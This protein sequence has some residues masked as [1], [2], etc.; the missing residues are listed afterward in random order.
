M[1]RPRSRRRLLTGS[2]RWFAVVALA[3][4]LHGAA[5][6]QPPSHSQVV[7]AVAF[8]AN[9]MGVPVPPDLPPVE[10]RSPD[11]LYASTAAVVSSRTRVVGTQ[12]GGAIGLQGG[13]DGRRLADMSWL[14]HETAHDLQPADRWRC[15]D[16]REAEAYRVQDAWLRAHGS[17]LAAIGVVPHELEPG[18]LCGVRVFD[19]RAPV[20]AGLPAGIFA[21]EPERIEIAGRSRP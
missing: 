6:A 7:A 3:G 20:T 12:R 10:L 11:A 21:I 9:E 17:S 2:I 13:W 4:L 5:D 15:Q 18:R 16:E 14:V 8:A 1:T 19:L